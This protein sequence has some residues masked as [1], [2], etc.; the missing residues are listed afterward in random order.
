MR[1]VCGPLGVSV[2]VCGPGVPVPPLVVLGNMVVCG[3][4]VVPE[5]AGADGCDTR[6]VVVLAVPAE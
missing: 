1:G 6:E 2:A 3:G 4:D 5:R